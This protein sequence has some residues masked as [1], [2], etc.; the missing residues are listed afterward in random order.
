MDELLRQLAGTGCA[1]AWTAFLTQ[2]SPVIR[3]IIVTSVS[4]PDDQGDCFVFVCEQLAARSFRRLRKFDSSGAASFP[5]W[6]RAVVRNL[7]IDWRRQ[8]S[9]R[10][11][12]FSWAE[13]LSALD[14][15]VF[16]CVY[17]QGYSAEYTLEFLAPTSPGLVLA[18]IEGSIERLAARM[19]PRERWLL[20]SR[21]VRLHS[22]DGDEE[23][24]TRCLAIPDL[25]PDPEQAASEHEYQEALQSAIAALV[26]ADQLLLQMRF[27]QELTLAEIAR[28]AGLKDP[29]S[30]DRRIK[31][32]VDQLRGKLA[33]FSTPAHGKTKSASV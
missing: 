7:C 25:A 27:E 24:G 4:D 1:T 11:Q 20:N 31:T 12:P 6:L 22:L 10:Y 32:I 15:Q 16:R 9:G 26:I 5:T 2:Y 33:R 28:L 23:T 21:K 30:A 17:E 3:Q 14:R 8:A 13:G 19:S 29:Q 18:Q